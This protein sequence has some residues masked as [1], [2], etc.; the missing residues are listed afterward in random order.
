MMAAAYRVFKDYD[1]DFAVKC[2]S[3]ALKAWEY[4]ENNPSIVPP[5]GFRNPENVATGEYGDWN[6]SDERLWAAAELF[7]ST[8]QQKF[9]D[10]FISL[11]S[12]I[13]SP[14]SWQNLKNLAVYTYYFAYEADESIKAKIE[15]DIKTYADSLVSRIEANPYKVVLRQTEYYW[16]S[17]SVLL[18]YAIDLIYAYEITKDLKYKKAALEQLHYILGR[19]ATSFCYVTGIGSK[20]P[21]SIHHRPSVALSKAIAGFLV[22]GPNSRG[23]DPYLQE[24]INTYNSAAAKCYID[25]YEAYSCNEVAINWNAPLVFVTA[26]FLAPTIQFQNMPPIYLN[27][28]YPTNQ[29]EIKGIVPLEFVL[30]ASTDIKKIEIYVNDK[31]EAT[32][33]KISIYHLDTTK[34]PDGDAVIKIVAYDALNNFAQKEVLVKFVNKLY[35]KFSKTILL[36][37]NDDELNKYIDFTNNS[38]I[39]VKKVSI[40]DAKGKLVKEL[41]KFPFIWDGKG[42]NNG[43]YIYYITT[44]QNSVIKGKIIIL[45]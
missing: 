6:D 39:D 25:N 8:H 19:N 37:P 38:S 41:K 24:Y 45:K 30:Y 15:Q 7:A 14:T 3:A 10:Y 27:I 2:L 43:L 31:I 13:N 20:S 16:G 33:N 4:L 40:Y 32:I 18:N 1:Y 44:K 9:S 23:N 12:P 28:T 42:V 5:H 11:Y 34:Y 35:S 29:K 26:Y 36:T 22:S 17:N 21:Q